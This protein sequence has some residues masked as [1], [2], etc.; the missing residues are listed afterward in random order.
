MEV[1]KFVIDE[2]P[3][4]CWDWELTRKN[5]EFLEGID[6]DYFGY[7]A[8]LNAPNIDGEDKHRAALSMRL[9]YSQGL[10][11]LFALL[12][13]AAQAPGCAIGWILNYT[14]ADLVN[15]V[16]KITRTQK[17]YTR[18]KSRPVTWQLLAKIIHGALSCETNKRLWIQEGFGNL[19]DNLAREFTDETFTLEYNGIK[20]GFRVRPGG[21]RFAIGNEEQRGVPAPGERMVSLGGSVFGTSYFVKES[22]L[23]KDKCNFRPRSHSRNW[24]PQNLANGLVLISMSINNV[25]SWLRSINGVQPNKCKFNNPT[26]KDQFEVLWKEHIGVRHI[27]IDSVITKDDIMPFPRQDIL[28]SYSETI[29][30]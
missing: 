19:W 21:F 7:V 20:H 15:L 6:A 1:V 24:S 10:E 27:A 22:I 3:Y 25:I 5:L 17:I 23:P 9:A 29:V 26:S 28:D 16:R 30:D 11:T 2:T 8:K 12:C 4:A 14:N 13:S 18:F